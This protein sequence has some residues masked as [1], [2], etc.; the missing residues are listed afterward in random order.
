MPPAMSVSDAELR[1][2]DAIHTI[3]PDD[4]NAAGHQLWGHRSQQS[5]VQPQPGETTL[6]ISLPSDDHVALL[7]LID[8]IELAKGEL[9]P[10]VRVLRRNLGP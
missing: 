8:R 3:D 2:A 5:Q 6:E 10:D 4:P 9:P 7:A 1:A